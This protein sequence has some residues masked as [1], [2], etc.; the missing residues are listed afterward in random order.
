[1]PFTVPYTLKPV[2]APSVRTLSKGSSVSS[3]DGLQSP[4][5]PAWSRS[6]SIED[7]GRQRDELPSSSP[8]DTRGRNDDCRRGSSGGE[9][10]AA[11][12]GAAPVES[13]PLQRT[14]TKGKEETCDTPTASKNSDAAEAARVADGS[15]GSDP[16]DV[17]KERH[18]NSFM[19]ARLKLGQTRTVAEPLSRLKARQQEPPAPE[20]MRRGSVPVFSQAMLRRPSERRLSSV[21]AKVAAAAGGGDDGGGGSSEID[22]VTSARDVKR[23]GEEATPGAA[24][25]DRKTSSPTKSPRSS[26]CKTTGMSIAS[27]TVVTT[28]GDLGRRDSSSA[29]TPARR[30][31]GAPVTTL[32]ITRKPSGTLTKKT[33]TSDTPTQPE[34]TVSKQNFTQHQVQEFKEA[35][36]FIDQDKDGFISKNDIR[37]TFDSLGRLTNDT[38]LESMISEA[39]GPINF[40]MFLTIFGDRITGV[41]DEEVIVNAFNLFD[42]GNGMCNEDRLRQMLTT[43]G[44]KLNEQEANDAFA[45]APVDSAGNVDLKKFASIL[46]KGV[47]EEEGA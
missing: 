44:E 4:R 23:E 2:K 26:P 32:R 14:A 5:S 10:A 34:A 11:V 45:E 6:A 27:T 30:G 46:T 33:E 16:K 19:E 17:E 41:D 36:Q 18:Y 38:E 24:P 1:M 35:F 40:T 12:D 42:Q 8:A 37:A 43:F 29:A 31:S 22:G 21:K 7:R 13:A 15:G 20:I 28:L 9:A 25:A 3:D 39:P 47:E